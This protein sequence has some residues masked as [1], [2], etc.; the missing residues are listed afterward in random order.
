[1]IVGIVPET[2]GAFL[3]ERVGWF[4]VRRVVCIP[5]CM[6]VDDASLLVAAATGMHTGTYFLR[7]RMSSDE[8]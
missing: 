8:Q 4:A 1:M 7:V 6:L 2:G 3:G 5:G